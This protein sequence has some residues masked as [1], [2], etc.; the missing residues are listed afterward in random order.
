MKREWYKLVLGEEK[1]RTIYH[2]YEVQ[3]ETLFLKL[4]SYVFF[5]LYIFL[6]SSVP[7]LYQPLSFSFERDHEHRSSQN[8]YLLCIP[9]L[10]LYS[11]QRVLNHHF[12]SSTLEYFLSLEPKRL[13]FSD[14][15]CRSESS[16]FY[17]SVSLCHIPAVM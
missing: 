12:K 13:H 16:L 5:L 8:Y 1:A 15:W 17:F 11:L 2:Y 7:S 4:F 14:R 9:N 3:W 6:F 10:T